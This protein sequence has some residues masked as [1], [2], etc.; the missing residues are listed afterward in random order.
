MRNVTHSVQQTL[1]NG[2][3]HTHVVAKWL[4]AMSDVNN[5]TEHTI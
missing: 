2:Q 3:T 1:T 4:R 5:D